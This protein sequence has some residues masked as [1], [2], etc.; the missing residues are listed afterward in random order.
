[1]SDNSSCSF[2]TSTPYHVNGMVTCSQFTKSGNYVPHGKVPVNDSIAPLCAPKGAV[3]ALDGPQVLKLGP[4]WRM[5]KLDELGNYGKHPELQ[6]FNKN[7]VVVFQV[8]NI[9]TAAKIPAAV[10][11]PA[12]A[13]HVLAGGYWMPRKALQCAATTKKGCRCKRT[14]LNGL[15]CWQH[16]RKPQ[17]LTSSLLRLA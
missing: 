16:N 3:L 2:V 9:S 1:M 6:R 13:P 12:S 17:V 10:S 8:P 5:V 7:C 14:I 15:Y 4:E 11:P